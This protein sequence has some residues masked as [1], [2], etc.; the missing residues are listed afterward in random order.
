MKYIIDPGN[1]RRTINVYDNIVYSHATDRSGK[2][3]ELKMALMNQNGNSEMRMAVGRD[4]EGNNP[5]QPVIVWVNGAGWHRCGRFLMS[6]EM[7]FLAEAGY[8]LALIEYRAS[9]ENIWPSQ[10]IDVKTAIR[11]LRAHASQYGLDP[12]HIGV[13]GRS[14]GGMIASWAGMNTD[15][16]DSE[17]WSEYS[18]KVQ[19]CVDMF[20]PVNLNTCTQINIE[21]FANPRSRWHK[22]VETHEGM[23]LGATE[24]T[25]D[26]EM[27]AMGKA[28]SPVFSISQ[29]MAPLCILHG[30]IDPVVPY[31]IS[32]D[33]YDRICTAG[34]E[35]KVE[36]YLVKNGSH[37]SR[38]MF[39][40]MTKQVILDFFQKH[41]Q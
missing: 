14:A 34:Y 38:E 37:G 10:L 41:L 7:Q 26:A 18:S 17:E 39:Q 23:L 5:P 21:G 32:E 36:Y 13:I 20:G 27:L 1:K 4:D 35:D 12:E 31:R 8:A 30:D 9:E 40:P 33:F 24:A 6:A 16:Y 11:F 19:A 25:T 29:A 3:I 28:A 22:H 15:G 2:P